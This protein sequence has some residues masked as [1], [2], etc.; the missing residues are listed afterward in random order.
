V[1]IFVTGGAGYIGSA[2]A[3]TFIAAG[4]EVVVFD[5]LSRGHR[6]AV[7]EDAAFVQGD[8]LDRAALDAAFETHRPDAVAHFAG[9]IEAAESMQQPGMYLH[10]NLTGAIHLLEAMI[11]HQCTQ[12]VFSSTAAVYASKNAPLN[13]DDPFGPSNLY[14]DT[15]LMIERMLGWY[16]RIHG[17][18]YAALRYFNAGGAMLNGDAQAVRGEAHQPESHLIPLTLQVPLGQRDKIELYGIDYPT[19]DGTCVRDYVHIEDLASAH[20]LALAALDDASEP[21]VYNLGNGR[22]YSNR[23]VIET[24]RA[25]T[26][27]PVPVEET[28]RRPGDATVLVASAEK[29]NHELG[30]VPKYPDLKDIISSAWEWHRSHPHGYMS[31]TGGDN[32]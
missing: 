21:L 16:H 5:N 4:H 31:K 15:K 1:K 6:E 7:P 12:M 17:L 9:F 24:A 20:V 14:G 29:V 28:D 11:T 27:H 22:G 19:P 26:G 18:K 2:T 13:E 30:W 10:N 23:E 25:V 8:M 3:A 32:E